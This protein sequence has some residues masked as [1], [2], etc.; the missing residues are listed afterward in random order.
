MSKRFISRRAS[1]IL[2]EDDQY[3]AFFK[4]AGLLAVPADKGNEASLTE[5]VN[6][7]YAAR[8]D[9]PEGLKLHPCHRID[10]DT[11]GVILFAKGQVARDHMMNLFRAREVQKKY[12]AFVHGKLLHS[13]GEMK[14][15][16]KEDIASGDRNSMSVTRYALKQQFRKFAVVE[17]TPLTGRTNQIRLHFKEVGNPLVG[18]NKFVYRK[19]FE[20]KFKRTALHA[21]ALSFVQPYTKDKVRI[22]AELSQDMQN[23]LVKER[24]K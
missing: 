15:R 24:S 18:E 7:E 23:F 10:R 11:S 19:D 5:I 1:I 3:I 8:P 13:R 2:Y 16:L 4:P 17:V 14:S 22:E 9:V 6:A 21:F 12:I 20:L